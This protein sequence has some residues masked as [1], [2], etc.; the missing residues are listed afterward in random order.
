M[1]SPDVL[2]VIKVDDPDQRRDIVKD[3]VAALSPEGG[4]VSLRAR[5]PPFGI[6]DT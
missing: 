5:L 4:L 2:A 6:V 1:T 3:A